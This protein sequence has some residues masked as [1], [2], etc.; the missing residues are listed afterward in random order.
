MSK[1]IWIELDSRHSRPIRALIGMMRDQI[2]CQ[3]GIEPETSGRFRCA[4]RTRIKTHMGYL[5]RFGLAQALFPDNTYA[6]DSG[7]DPNVIPELT[8]D[9]FK[10]RSAP[11]Y[12]VVV[13][14][15]PP[16]SEF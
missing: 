14:E 5:K 9:E 13:M 15:F 4:F 11:P 8:Y 7:G 2:Q 6:V 3:S 12:A 16:V 10:V 1:A